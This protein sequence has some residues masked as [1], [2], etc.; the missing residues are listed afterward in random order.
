MVTLP[1]GNGDEEVQ[2]IQ[3]MDIHK[4][5]SPSKISFSNMNGES[6]TYEESADIK[7]NLILSMKETIS[8]AYFARPT[9]EVI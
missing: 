5:R 8:T 6:F 7:K 4:L 9:S 2:E 3:I 1:P